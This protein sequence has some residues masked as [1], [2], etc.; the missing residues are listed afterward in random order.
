MGAALFG[1]APKHPILKHCLDTM[2]LD[3][4]KK[5]A[6][7]KTGPVHFT[8]SFFAT[9]GKQGVCDIALPAHYFYPLGCREG[10]DKMLYRVWAEQGAYAIHHWAKSWMPKEYRP[11]QFRDLK[12]DAACAGW[13][14]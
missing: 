1:G 7:T 8:R 14:D 12:N 10:Q 13:N 2:R 9:A 11:R 4:N 3:W 5:G 6:P